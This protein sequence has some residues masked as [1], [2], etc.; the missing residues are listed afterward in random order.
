MRI[1]SL[2]VTAL[3]AL[4]AL[5]APA[6][7]ANTH[8]TLNV[9]ASVPMGRDSLQRPTIPVRMDGHDEHLLV[10]TGGVISL[11]APGVVRAL[12]AKTQPIRGGSFV[13]ATGQVPTTMAT[14]DTLQVGRLIARN[15][16]F[17]VLPDPTAMPFGEVG[18]FGA[19]FL[20]AWDVDFDF[21]NNR[22]NLISP[23][24]C[25]GNVVYWT[26]SPYVARP[27]RLN[28]N[29]H[30][31][32]EVKLD[33]HNLRAVVDTGSVSSAMSLDLARRLYGVKESEL[34]RPHHLRGNAFGPSTKQFKAFAHHFQMLN[35]DGIAVKNPKIELIRNLE[36]GTE[37]LII[38][39][40]LLSKLHLY[41]AYREKVLYITLANTR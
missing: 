36:L 22:F 12:K 19:D 26:K 6:F 5:A 35:L 4:A 31:Q 25:K 15:A 7:A 2:I 20:S 9:A 18:S 17:L 40:S 32:I 8:C 37:Q 1:T 24:H 39:M 28:A 23:K 41:V 33:G 21:G 29:R 11:I 30:I 14:I 38:G 10:D 34:G 13:I 27:F 16:K 3:W